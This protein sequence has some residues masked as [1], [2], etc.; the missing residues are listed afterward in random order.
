MTYKE[1]KEKHQQEV[2]AFPFGFAF[3]K[4]QFLDMMKNWGL[5]H[6]RDGQPTLNDL[7]QIASIGAGGYVRKKDISDMHAMFNRQ[8]QEL[9]E[10]ILADKTGDGF[11][12]QMFYEEMSDHEFD[13]TQDT[14]ETLHALGL[15]SSQVENN[16]ALASG[17]RKAQGRIFGKN[18]FQKEKE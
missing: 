8:H 17:W 3:D 2:N 16:P 14:D 15:T 10:A 13:W 5:C 7:K 12:F 9:Q 6:G 1:M 18:V 11:I 4:D